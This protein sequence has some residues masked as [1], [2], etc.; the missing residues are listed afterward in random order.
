MPV[1]L[2]VILVVWL[3]LVDSLVHQ[4]HVSH[5]C[6]YSA[7][8]LIGTINALYGETM[9]LMNFAIVLVLVCM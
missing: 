8:V 6:R 7:I 9:Y 1:C 5:A 2:L 4:C 3:D